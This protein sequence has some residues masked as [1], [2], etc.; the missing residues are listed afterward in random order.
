M[1]Y[2]VLMSGKNRTIM[3]EFFTYMDFSFECMS[4]SDRYDDIVN[5]IKY[6]K[7]DV[8]V[9]CLRGEKPDDIKKYCN[10][11]RKLEEKEI[12][13]WSSG[14]MRTVNCLRELRFSARQQF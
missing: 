8:F 14:M 3:N 9:Y 4:C 11:E 10:V 5:H 13:S 12:L 7:P 1:K 2:K 6:V